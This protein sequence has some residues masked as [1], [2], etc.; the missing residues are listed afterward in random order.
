MNGNHSHDAQVDNQDAG[1]TGAALPRMELHRLAAVRRAKGISCYDL[2]RQL[3]ITV[4]MVRQQEESPDL[5]IS[6]LEQWAEGLGVPVTELILEPEEWLNA[7]NLAKSQV[8]RLLRLATS[9]RD[10]SRRRSI[11]RLAQTFVDQ[12]TE[13]YPAANPSSNSNGHG[14]PVQQPLRSRPNGKSRQPPKE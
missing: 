4:E 5:S 9:L 13:I 8:D 11:Q 10:G 3:G 7:T 1:A 12:L 6:T 2:A 14:G